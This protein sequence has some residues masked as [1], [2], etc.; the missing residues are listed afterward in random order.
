LVRER[1]LGDDSLEFGDEYLPAEILVAIRSLHDSLAGNAVV[2]LAAEWIEL[3]TERL[4][5]DKTLSE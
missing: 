1:D 5:L 4:C 3:Q 2:I